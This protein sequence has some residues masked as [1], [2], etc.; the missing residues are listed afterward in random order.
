MGELCY[1][2]IVIT[3]KFNVKGRCE[4]AENIGKQ[5][6]NLVDMGFKAG[7]KLKSE[8]NWVV[9]N[10]TILTDGKQNVKQA[11]DFI[12]SV[13]T[14]AQEPIPLFLTKS[15]AQIKRGWT[16]VLCY[17][18]GVYNGVISNAEAPTIETSEKGIL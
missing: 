6:D 18:T 3:L 11:R 16:N 2:T 1:N 17:I 9:K 4:L 14:K 13:A 15:E 5:E 12:I 10:S 8:K 7:S